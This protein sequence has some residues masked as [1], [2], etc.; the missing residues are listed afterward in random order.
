[1]NTLEVKIQEC[2]NRLEIDIAY[3]R[4]TLQTLE[5]TKRQW[6]QFLLLAYI[7]HV[8][9]GYPSLLT[10]NEYQNMQKRY[11][12]NITNLAVRTK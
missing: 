4:I 1:M 10:T 6:E 8:C 2:H 9:G 5:S 3:A 12:E 11:D 7:D